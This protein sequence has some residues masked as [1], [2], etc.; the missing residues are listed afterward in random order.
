MREYKKMADILQPC[1]VGN[2]KIDI[3]EISNDDVFCFIRN[4]IPPGKYARLRVN[5]ETMMSETPMEERTNIW[6]VDN[7]HGDVLIGGLGIGMIVLAIQDDPRV[8]SI[9]VL[10][11][12]EN[13]ID[14]VKPQ[15]PLNEK[16]RVLCMD[17]FTWKPDRKFDCIYMDIWPYINSDVYNEM[18]KLKRKYGHYLKPLDESPERFNKCWAERQAKTNSRLW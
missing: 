6:F 9:T 16:V 2:A 11:I 18:K 3:F 15:L 12:N 5:G 1:K 10:E 8:K 7:A 13:V 4:G 17:A 14:A